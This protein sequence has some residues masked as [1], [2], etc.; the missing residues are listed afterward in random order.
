MATSVD[1]I[2][3]GVERM[4]RIFEP[5]RWQVETWQAQQLTDFEPV[6]FG[7]RDA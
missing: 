1:A 4:Q 7:R 3:V 5:M 6:S 2:C